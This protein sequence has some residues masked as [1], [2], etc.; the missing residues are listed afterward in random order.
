MDTQQFHDTMLGGVTRL[1]TKV[2]SIVESVEGLNK[3][4]DKANGHIGE[5]FEGLRASELALV[6]HATDCPAKSKINE[7]E[8]DVRLA[9]ATSDAIKQTSTK[10]WT[11]IKPY[12]MV[13]AGAIALLLLEHLSDLIKL[14]RGKP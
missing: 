11:E 8:I 3:R 7:L 1:E 13:V 5:L 6:S 9:A 4:F 14:W 2:E 10:W 12:I